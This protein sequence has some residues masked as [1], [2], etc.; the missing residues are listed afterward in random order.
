MGCLT[1]GPLLV[2]AWCALGFAITPTAQDNSTQAPKVDLPPALAQ[3]LSVAAGRAQATA[4]AFGTLRAEIGRTANLDAQIVEGLVPEEVSI[5]NGSSPLCEDLGARFQAAQLSGEEL[6]RKLSN[7][8]EAEAI[9]HTPRLSEELEA[10]ARDLDVH[11][12][13]VRELA[14]S[15]LSS[16]A[17]EKLALAVAP[18]GSAN[19]GNTAM[20]G[21]HKIA[22]AVASDL[23]RLNTVARQLADR[24]D[25]SMLAEARRLGAR[26]ARLESQGSR[27][28]EEWQALGH[29]ASE[30]LARAEQLLQSPRSSGTG[31]G[32][33]SSSGSG[34]S[35]KGKAAEAAPP[36][37]TWKPGDPCTADAVTAAGGHFDTILR[38]FRG[39]LL[40]AMLPPEV[41]NLH[42][43]VHALEVMKN[44]LLS[45]FT[46]AGDGPTPATAGC[47]QYFSGVG[48]LEADL[49]HYNGLLLKK[50]KKRRRKKQQQGGQNVPL[51][52]LS[53]A[54]P[55][56]SA[57]T[58]PALSAIRF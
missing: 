57:R 49:G 42:R 21:E 37:F 54:E 39:Q 11:F 17:R 36:Q 6:S 9:E 23:E 32:S 2:V 41:E 20:R 1:H 10:L 58:R 33:S 15:Q 22:G 28:D 19:A 40:K 18:L 31:S 46:R 48:Q 7:G 35:R 38:G 26:H 45:D 5:L 52:T 34:F 51:E 14:L 3:R 55:P 43:V 27:D 16:G 50:K 53:I 25:P 8:E 13:R 56:R 47:E 4:V 30:T 29:M 12:V 24:A 44:S